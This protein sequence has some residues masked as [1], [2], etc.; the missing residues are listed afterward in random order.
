[1]FKSLITQLKLATLE[2]TAYI[3]VYFITSFGLS[4]VLILKPLYATV[5]D[6]NVTRPLNNSTKELLNLFLCLFN[7]EEIYQ[8]ISSAFFSYML[9]FS[10]FNS[11]II[12][13][14]QLFK[15]RYY[16]PYCFI[17]TAFNLNR[18]FF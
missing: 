11:I 9:K 4:L 7:V 5:T 10:E 12:I 1:L 6:T 18:L 16:F 13:I 15:E 14:N 2:K 17:I 3:S 8:L